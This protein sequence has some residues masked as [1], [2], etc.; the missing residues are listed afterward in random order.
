M[1]K[2]DN[3]LNKISEYQ[4]ELV[5]IQNNCGHTKKEIKFINQKEGVRWICKECKM[6]I[7]WPTDFELKKWAKK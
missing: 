4:R 6:L 5:K 7:G 1:G 3:I 2:A